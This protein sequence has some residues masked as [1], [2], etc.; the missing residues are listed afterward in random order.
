MGLQHLGRQRDTAESLPTI[1]SKMGPI[2]RNPQ[3]WSTDARGY[4]CFFSQSFLSLFSGAS[5]RPE[6]VH[7]AAE[8]GL[9]SRGRIGHPISDLPTSGWHR[10]LERKHN[11]SQSLSD[12][13]VAH[14]CKCAP[15][16]SDLTEEPCEAQGTIIDPLFFR[17]AFCAHLK[18]P[19]I[20]GQSANQP[21]INRPWWMGFLDKPDR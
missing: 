8:S 6:T 1:C 10:S 9:L 12:M 3:P 18:R 11:L 20:A 15:G 2:Y 7:F 4:L 14:G 13:A 17:W 5:E 19:S 21:L 16:A